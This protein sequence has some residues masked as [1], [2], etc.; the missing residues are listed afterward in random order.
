MGRTWGKAGEGNSE[1]VGMGGGAEK[2]L[3]NPE[4]IKRK[5]KRDW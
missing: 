2:T 4:G 1:A 3:W 5:V